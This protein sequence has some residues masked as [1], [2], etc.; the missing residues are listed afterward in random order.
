MGLIDDASLAFTAALGASKQGTAYSLKPTDGSGDFAFTRADDPNDGG[1]DL[2]A[3]FI[4][5]QGYI[6][7]GYENFLFYSNDFS[8]GTWGKSSGTIITGGEEGYDGSNDAWLLNSTISNGQVSQN[9]VSGLSTFSVYAKES[10]NG[11]ISLRAENPLARVWFD[12][13]TSTTGSRIGYN[14]GGVHY[15]I[16]DVGNGWFKC[17]MTI[18][19]VTSSVR[20]HSCQDNVAFGTGSIY[21]QDAMLNEG[22]VAM[23]YIESGASKAQKGLVQD[24]PRFTFSNGTRSLLLE[25]ERTNLNKWSQYLRLQQVTAEYNQIVSPDG[26]KNALLI[27][28]DTALNAHGSVVVNFFPQNNNAENYTISVFAKPKERK[29]LQFQ[30]YVDGTS[31]TSSVFFLETAYTEGDPLTHKIEPYADDWYRYSFTASLANTSGGYHFARVLMLN[32]SLSSYYQG[33]GNS[34]MYLYG[35]QLEKGSYPTS[36]IPTNG[37]TKTRFADNA[38]AAVTNT[39]SRTYFLDGKRLAD[40]DYRNSAFFYAPND[41]LSITFWDGNKIRFR[42]GGLTN[43]Y[44]TLVGDDFKIAIS[45]DGVDCII[46]IN[47]QEFNTRTFDLVSVS[48]ITLRGSKGAVSFNKTLYFPTALS[49][50]E[51]IELTTL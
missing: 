42:F 13:R 1:L 24:E 50:D 6:E 27:K 47:G 41:Y 16:E 38:V 14:V 22:L 7:K 19:G 44:Y 10:T 12:L 32:S 2:A 34:G 51:C 29:H 46:Y 18:T 21:I 31:Y 30:F 26:Y 45:Y 8:N 35:L 9:I 40:E 36:L 39:T 43:D 17:S 33:D 11:W 23:P 4:N 15:D 5:K 48:S 28:E 3:T 37:T 49:H 25:P 20:I